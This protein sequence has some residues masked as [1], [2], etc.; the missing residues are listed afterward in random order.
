MG[1]KDQFQDKADELKDRAQNGAKGAKDE[2][3]HKATQRT[4]KPQEKSKRGPQ[5]E[6]ADRL[7]DEFDA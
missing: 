1:I 7:R 5:Q 3:T 6:Q 2:A 4:A